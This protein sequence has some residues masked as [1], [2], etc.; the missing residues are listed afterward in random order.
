MSEAKQ[1][2]LFSLTSEFAADDEDSSLAKRPRG[3]FA[4]LAQKRAEHIFTYF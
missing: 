1:K 4:A 3:A 2:L